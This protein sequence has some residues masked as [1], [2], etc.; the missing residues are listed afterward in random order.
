MYKVQHD[1]SKAGAQLVTEQAFAQGE[2]VAAIH[3]F[4]VMSTP[5]YQ[6][7]QIGPRQ[8]I[9]DT[10]VI[11]YMN[12]SCDPNTEIDTTTLIIRAVRDIASGEPLTFFYPSTEWEMERSFV[13][14]CS[15]E[16][17][18]GLVAGAKYLSVA[19]LSCYFVNEHICQMILDALSP[20]RGSE[21][22]EAAPHHRLET[23]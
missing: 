12:H 20:L 16:R 5:T 6:S 9:E 1:V 7:I 10:G 3:D 15:S 11:V 19:I 14:V 13:C 2:I 22:V 18:V 8:H 17:C 4:T 21:M 23:V